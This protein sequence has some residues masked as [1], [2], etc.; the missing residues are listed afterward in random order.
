[1]EN[2]IVRIHFLRASWARRVSTLNV[3]HPHL[4]H[5]IDTDF[6][7]IRR[8]TQPTWKRSRGL[9]F[10]PLTKAYAIGASARSPIA[11]GA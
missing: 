10:C 1:M 9:S 7:E 6:T 5:F 3:Q 11:D 8:C 2:R 4:T